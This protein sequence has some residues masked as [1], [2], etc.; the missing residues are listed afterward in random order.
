M[1]KWFELLNESRKSGKGL[2]KSL[3]W[4]LDKGPQ[5]KGG[6]PKK[7]RPNFRRKKFNDIS[8]RAG[9]A[10]GLKKKSNQNHSLKQPN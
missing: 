6:Y 2:K 3:K 5:K 10:G 1:D 8:A 7:R 4:F 9:A